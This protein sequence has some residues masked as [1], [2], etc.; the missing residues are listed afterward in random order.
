MSFETAINI[1]DVAKSYKI[2][3]KP[4][5]RLKQFF[6]KDKKKY[7]EEFFALS[8][9]S[10]QV[11]KG[12]IV[13]IVGKN[14]SGKSTLLQLVAGIITPSNG[15]IDVNGR[16]AALL[17]L[18]SGFNPDYTGRENV[19][20]NGSILGVSPNEMDKRFQDIVDFADIGS[21]IDQPVRTYSSGMYIRLAFAVAINVDA[22][23]LIIDEALAVGDIRFQIKC[24]EK[25]KHLRNNGT[26][27][28]FVSHSPEQVKRFCNRAIWLNDGKIKMIGNADEVVNAYE[29]YMNVSYYK[30]QNREPNKS[31]KLN[32]NN[33]NEG[34]LT[35]IISISS[36]RDIFKTFEELII[37]VEYEIFEE[38]INSF[39][40]GVAIYGSD[41]K[42]IFG[43]NTYLDNYK[44]PNNRGKHNVLYRIPKIPLLAGSYYIDVG[45]FTDEGLV[46][47]DYVTNALSIEVNNSYFTEGLV[48]IEHDWKVV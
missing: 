48:Y 38:R 29:D 42:Y 8:Q 12:D 19:Y 28:L 9:V 43:P 39:L 35:N 21:F 44:V 46:C 41:R 40:L 45:I 11:R 14:G 6:Y 26:T 4:I 37:E 32:V 2:Y 23:I 34:K 13:G 3:S 1:N 17:E 16:V 20:M 24:I 10:F 30:P 47:L 15:Q 25:L 7:Y 33:R 5:D 31:N 36:N 18:G 27:I 22:D